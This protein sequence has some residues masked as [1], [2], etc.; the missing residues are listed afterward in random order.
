MVCMAVNKMS[1]SNIDYIG[2]FSVATDRFVLI[3]NDMTKSEKSIIEDTFKL[4]VVEST[5]NW[6][7]FV[8]IYVA[9]NSHGMLVPGFT[10]ESEIRK[11][12][13]EIE[14]VNIGVFNTD[15]NALRNNILLNDRIA[16][17][18]PDYN[19]SEVKIMS[20]ILG[21]EVIKTEIA[22]M[23]TV[24]ANN[25][26]T[27]KGVVFNNEIGEDEK[28]RLSKMLN[29]SGEQSTA[30]SGSL[31][32]GLCTITNSGGLIVGSSTTGYE[33]SQIMDSLNV[34]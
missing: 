15:L 13:Q 23:K 16:L 1:I 3:A 32:I 5:I 31:S 19:S 2:A 11:L 24:G 30:N 25:I 12:K 28:R 17:V 29:V 27:N 10:E 33:I 6:S 21:V 9:A 26:L 7:P 20:D 34:E 4:K 8:G 14:D 18:N 22:G